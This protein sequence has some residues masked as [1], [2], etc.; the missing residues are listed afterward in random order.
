MV[1]FEQIFVS[2]RDIVAGRGYFENRHDYFSKAVSM[3][4]K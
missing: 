1:L 4:D 3:F 2:I